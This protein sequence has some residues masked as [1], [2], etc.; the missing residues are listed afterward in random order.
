MQSLRVKWMSVLA[1]FVTFDVELMAC[2][3]KACFL[4][5]NVRIASGVTDCQFF[6]IKMMFRQS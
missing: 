1:L 6:P 2:P 3:D 5:T 4:Q